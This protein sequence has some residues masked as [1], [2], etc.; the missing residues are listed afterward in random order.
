MWGHATQVVLKTQFIDLVHPEDRTRTMEHLGRLA[1]EFGS[2]RFEPRFLTAD[3]DW[4][5]IS[6][7]ATPWP[8]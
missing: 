1:D 3:G 2:I 7:T 4:R 8:D 5:W 6:W